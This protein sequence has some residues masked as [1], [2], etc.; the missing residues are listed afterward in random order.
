MAICALKCRTVDEYV[1]DSCIS[2]VFSSEKLHTLLNALSPAYLRVSGTSADWLFFD[3][4]LVVLQASGIKPR[5]NVMRSMPVEN[6]FMRR[7]MKLCF[8]S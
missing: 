8:F 6:S 4:P 1:N 2:F 3:K 5:P 7:I